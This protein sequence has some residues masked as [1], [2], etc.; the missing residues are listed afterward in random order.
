M[1]SFSSES[2][3]ERDR[4]AC[5]RVPVGMCMLT[6]IYLW[7]CAR[8]HIYACG[9]VHAHTYKSAPEL[10]R[11]A[12][13]T[14]RM[15]EVFPKRDYTSEHSNARKRGNR[16]RRAAVLRPEVTGVWAHPDQEAGSFEG[17]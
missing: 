7:A 8:S 10:T 1:K 9:H 12:F 13:G 6:H 14:G 11:L 17:R 3:V 4:L 16:S 5:T 2:K 15:V